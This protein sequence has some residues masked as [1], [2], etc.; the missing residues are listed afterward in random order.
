MTA[1]RNALLAY[2]GAL[3]VVGNNVSNS[4]NPDHTRQTADLT[5]VA[6]GLVGN[7][8]RPGAGVSLTAIRRNVDEALENRLR[9]ANGEVEYNAATRAALAEIEVFFDD[10]SGAGI[11]GKLVDFFNALSDVQNAPQDL[12]I[13]QVVIG[14]ADALATSL[15]SARD[16]LG[17][18]GRRL[19]DQIKQ[20]V[21]DANDIAGRIAE[22]NSQI[23]TAEAG[24]TS[25]SGPL[26]DRRDAL[27]RELSHLLEIQTAEQPDGSVIVYA[28][29]EPLIQF[30]FSRGLSTED[31]A[32]GQSVRTSVIFADSNTTLVN[33]GGAI[34]GLIRARDDQALGRIAAID[35]LAEGIIAE[36]NAVHAD[37]QGLTSLRS[38]TSVNHIADPDAALNSLDAAL[39]ITPDN[40]SF[41]ISVAD[42]AT[43]ST[44]AHRIEVDLDGEGTDTTLNDIINQINTDVDGVTATLTADNRLNLDAD[45][46]F[47]FTFGHDGDQFRED[48]SGLLAALGVNTFFEG[49]GAAD[50]RV[51]QELVADPGLLAAASLNRVGDGL[52]AGRMGGLI[53][54]P[55]DALGQASILQF[56]NS[57]A[58]G[59]AADG[60]AAR[61][62]LESAEAVASA[63]EQKRQSISGV[64]LDEEAIELLKFERAFQGAARYV[65]VVDNL[66]QEMLTL[67]Q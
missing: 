15:R 35:Q 30:G 54:M 19:N 3:Q 22:L 37:G 46:G 24:N 34:G 66:M 58:N 51:R 57:V 47:S 65:S 18:I 67:L 32:N 33:P 41:F 7:G 10:Q 45:T 2:Q 48:T 25:Q 21:E 16:S 11:S 26:R 14:T 50:I 39:R 60:A 43:G 53:D 8:L 63:L 56:Y 20:R 29:S 59:V 28:G 55:S 62:S 23:V 17:E 13:R 40:G 6:G 42:D 64:S 49:S 4:G 61:N 44:V 27:L 9:T 31:V 5:S 1:G 12:A 36:V 38:V 52:N